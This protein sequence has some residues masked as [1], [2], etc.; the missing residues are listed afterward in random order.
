MPPRPR[1]SIVCPAYQ[2][3]DVLPR[4]HAALAPA[5]APLEAE[6]DLEILYVDDGSRD[7][8]LAVIR[9]L[10]AADPRVRYVSL[11]RNFGHQVALT[12]GLDH[13]TG[14]AVVS[15]DSDLQHPPALIPALVAKWRE[16]CDVVLTVRSDDRRL[17][18]FKRAS[19]RAFYRLLAAVSTVEVRPAAADFRL[20]SR[21]AAD[22]LG[23]LREPHRYVRGMVQWL[24]FPAAEVP[25]EP[26]PRQGGVS[27]Y[28]LRRMLRFAADGLLS[29]SPAPVRLAAAFGLA[30]TGA[31]WVLSTTAVALLVPLAD[32]AARVGLVLLTA[33]HAIAAGGLVAAGVI[34]E[35]LTRIYEQAK[36]RPLYLVKETSPAPVAAARPARAA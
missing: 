7:R 1:L 33:L 23:R 30:V 28:T 2:E 9:A 13:A 32:P 6:F 14:D 19:S 10:A 16:G 15:L 8:T 25:F 26:A 11:S 17:G 22:E 34:G 20:L 4:F 3:E 18:W 12:A 35:Y 27:K 5:V 29:F 31:S 21:R 24:G 36:D